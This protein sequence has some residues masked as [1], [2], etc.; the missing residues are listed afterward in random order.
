MSNTGKRLLVDA[1]G[2]VYIEEFAIP[3]P[4]PGQIL[5]RTTTTQVSAGSEMNVV[6]RRRQASAAEQATFAPQSIGYTAIGEVAAIGAGVTDFAVGDRVFYSGNHSTHWLVTP[7]KA[8][9]TVG[10][11]QEFTIEKI[12]AGLSDLEAA[13]CVL[14]DI[15]LHG[16]RLAQLQI[17]E[18]VAVH[19]VGVIGQLAIQLCRASG[20]YPVIAVDKVA[21]RLAQAQ[22][23][24]ATNL[25]NA[26][27]EDVIERIRALTAVPWRWRGALPGMEPGIGAD[28]QLHCTSDIS[29]YPT[30]IKAAA[31]RGRI[32]LVGATSGSVPIESNELFRREL[33]LRGSYQT[34]M[35][36]AHPYWP[37][38]RARN[39]RI[40]LE[41]ITRGDLQVKPLISH[42][43]PYQEAPPLYDL[44]MNAGPGWMGVF[45]TWT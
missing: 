14:G 43:V 41:M 1:A 42:V 23:L 28:V 27:T 33:T 38:T 7:A 16:V 15:A 26:Q 25:I 29:N 13:F 17:G 40:I 32:I 10:I 35:S 9:E 6:R 18:A 24:G 8:L 22:N 2:Q 11:P 31:D 34:G 44:M 4:G 36:D 3:T 5:V 37:W 30:L 19:G 45:F 39:R 21:E 20:A 12:P